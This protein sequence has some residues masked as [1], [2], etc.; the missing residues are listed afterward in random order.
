MVKWERWPAV[1]GFAT[2]AAPRFAPYAQ[3]EAIS[4]CA[5][6]L[7]PYVFAIVGYR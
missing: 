2:R 5:P 7:P 4:D 1:D 3:N 6:H